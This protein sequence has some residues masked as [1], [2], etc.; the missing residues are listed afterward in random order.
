MGLRSWMKGKINSR[1]NGPRP[2]PQVRAVKLPPE[3]LQPLEQQFLSLEQNLLRLMQDA[4]QRLHLR[5]DSISKS[6]IA[7]RTELNQLTKLEAALK[8]L[9]DDVGKDSQKLSLF[10]TRFKKYAEM[11]VNRA[12][13][14]FPPDGKLPP[15][16]ENM[17]KRI[18]TE[19]ETYEK[20]SQLMLQDVNSM[21]SNDVQASANLL[22]TEFDDLTKEYKRISEALISLSGSYRVLVG[23]QGTAYAALEHIHAES[24]RRV[25]EQVANM[26]R[27]LGEE[28][29]AQRK[30]NSNLKPRLNVVIN[31]IRDDSTRVKGRVSRLAKDRK[32]LVMDIRS[33]TQRASVLSKANNSARSSV[34]L[35]GPGTK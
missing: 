23:G 32:Q 16:L 5:L 35:L 17:M 22:K 11:L 30:F 7:S 20:E 26:L 10:S 34:L 31:S 33:F 28:A 9:R 13:I 6:T 21:L 14:Y 27:V 15:D 25:R 3:V 1:S 19:M 8:K 12:K 4:N 24:L 2:V 29:E 18:R